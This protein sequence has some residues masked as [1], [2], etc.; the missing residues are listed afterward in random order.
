MEKNLQGFLEQM[1]LHYEEL[2]GMRADD[3]S[4]IGIRFKILAE[5]LERLYIELEEA[6]KQAFAATA[7]GKYLEK[8]AMQRGIDR[9]PAICARG[10]VCFSRSQSAAVDLEIPKGILLMCSAQR[11]NPLR[12]ITT[13]RVVMK[14]GKTEVLAA[15]ECQTA[16]KQGNL[17]AGMLTVMVTPVQGIAQVSN[18]QALVSGEDAESDE[19]LRKRLMD[20]YRAVTNGTNE[21]FYYHKAMEYPGVSS[22]KVLPRVNGKGTVGILVWGEGVDDLLLEKMKQEIGQIK[23]INVD[24]TVERAVAKPISISA[25]IAVEDGYSYEDVSKECAKVLSEY[26]Q[27]RQIGQPLYSAMLMKEILGCTGVANCSIIMPEQDLYPL[28][29]E[30]FTLSECSVSQMEHRRGGE[31]R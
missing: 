14:A 1:Q 21:A 13:E 9:K 26:M 25:K 22:A 10:K 16:G 30:I 15:V 18:P 20:S 19:S 27:H 2:S 28:E 3:A 11:E 12:F 7:T 24:M 5:Q 29:K 6:K 4:D 17:A 23:E 8:H 31:S